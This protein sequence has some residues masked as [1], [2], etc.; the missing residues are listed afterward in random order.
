[1]TANTTYFVRA[2]ATNCVGTGYGDEIS[3]ITTGATMPESCPGLPSITD[4]D[5]NIYNTV[6]IG[7]QCWTK[8]N[9]KV[10]KYNDGTLIPIDS[11]GTGVNGDLT[12]FRRTSGARTIY[13]HSQAN[14]S[15]YGYLY[16]WYAVKGIDTTGS[17]SYK[18]IC[19]T[20]WHVPTD[21]E[22]DTLTTFLGG[23][24]MAGGKMKSTGTT[25][26]HSPNIDA[27]NGS[28]FTGLPGGYRDVFGSFKDIKS[29][30]FFWSASES[31]SGPWFRYLHNSNSY[32]YR[33]YYYSK[34]VG[35]SVRCLKD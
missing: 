27:T 22:W 23:R 21:E 32:V 20:G 29:G 7:T 12:W 17:T 28:G 11:S 24:K 1:L 9:L 35:A 34:N 14:F 18:N 30:F 2:Y 15:T 16:N 6:Q 31:G 33:I 4:I 19:P 5:G 10:T 25:L 13:A 3:F 26:W 8:E